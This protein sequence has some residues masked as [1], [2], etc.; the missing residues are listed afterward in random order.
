MATIKTQLVDGQRRIITKVVNGQRRVSCSC[1]EEGECCMY[2]ADQLGV[3]YT[4]DDLPDKIKFDGGEFTKNNPPIPFTPDP[5]VLI[6]YG[7]A[8]EGLGI[9]DG[10]GLWRQF[11]D[12]GGSGGARC[13]IGNIGG[14]EFSDDFA[15][16][17][18][19]TTPF[20][21]GVVERQAL[22]RW[23]GTDGNG[24]LLQLLYGGFGGDPETEPAEGALKWSVSFREYEEPEGLPA[25]CTVNY[26]RLK[27][28][29]QNSPIGTYDISYAT[30]GPEFATVS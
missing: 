29:F 25:G 2:P 19:I 3:G 6:Y 12:F 23:D 30:D 4:V 20:S 5:S 1:C 11:V 16:I 26:G 21:S 10:E 9:A 8:G 22:C 7:F 13:L 15:D 24:C 27:S 18:T 17:Y 28:G 14:V